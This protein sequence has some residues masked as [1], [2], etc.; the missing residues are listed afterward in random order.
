MVLESNIRD[1]DLLTIGY[2]YNKSD[3]LYFVATKRAGCTQPGYPY[4]TTW[5]DQI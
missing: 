2:K 4:I 1:V 3:I 5:K